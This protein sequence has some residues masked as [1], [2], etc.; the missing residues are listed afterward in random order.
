MT[1][2]ISEVVVGVL[3]LWGRFLPLAL[4]LFAPVLVNILL[5]HAFLQT[6]GTGTALLAGAFYFTSC[7]CIAT[8]SPACSRRSEQPWRSRERAAPR[9]RASISRATLGGHAPAAIRTR[10]SP[11]LQPRSR[12]KGASCS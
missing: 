9:P 2:A 6:A 10:R 8:A 12:R 5:F 11:M 1:V 4:A 7:T 3:L